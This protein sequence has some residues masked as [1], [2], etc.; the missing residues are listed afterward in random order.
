MKAVALGLAVALVSGAV[1][2]AFEEQHFG[3]FSVYSDEP[4][5]IYLDGSIELGAADDFMR[6]RR[7]APEASTLVLASDGGHVDEAEA[8][9]RQVRGLGLATYVPLQS[10][11]Y[12][13]CAYIFFAGVDRRAT[14][15]LGV[16]QVSD[17]GFTAHSLQR[18]LADLLDLLFEFGVDTR[19]ATAMLRTPPEALYVLDGR[20]IAQLGVDVDGAQSLDWLDERFGYPFSKWSGDAA[21]ACQ[22]ITAWS[23]GYE[24]CVP[25]A[26]IPTS[27]EPGETYYYQDA[28]HRMGLLIRDEPGDWTRDEL[29]DIVLDTAAAQ[30][31]DGALQELQWPAA[32]GTFDLMIYPGLRNGSEVLYQHFYRV[33]P[34]GG[35]LQVLVYS[36]AGQA[37]QASSLAAQLFSHLR[38]DDVDP[39][40]AAPRIRMRD[41]RR[42]G[43]HPREVE[44]AAR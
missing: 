44:S 36:A 37:W 11:C 8:I 4:E 20:E 2:G 16:H 34:E 42:S 28:E 43:T 38:I 19:I 3:S 14:G 30:S 39:A 27:P 29:R 23:G 40:P 12:S 25:A 41:D 5:L 24:V 32:G 10:G 6:A 9:A 13:A 33:L 31:G 18:D 15:Q 17:P 35:G 7:A 22:A 21:D 26:W 1:A